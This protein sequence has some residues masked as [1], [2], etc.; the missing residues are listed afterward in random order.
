MLGL[1]AIKLAGTKLEWDAAEM[2][3]T[4]SREANAFLNPPA[5]KGWTL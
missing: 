5:R 1:I 3:F 4:N 2:K